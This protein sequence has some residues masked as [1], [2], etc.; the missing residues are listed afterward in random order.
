MVIAKTLNPPPGN[1]IIA[2]P[3]LLPLGGKTVNVGEV[4]S[5]TASEVWPAIASGVSATNTLS[6]GWEIPSISGAPLGQ[7]GTCFSP[8]GGC[9]TPAFLTSACCWS[10][11]VGLFACVGSDLSLRVTATPQAKPNKPKTHARISQVR[12]I[13]DSSLT[14]RTLVTIPYGPA[15]DPHADKAVLSSSRPGNKLRRNHST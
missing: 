7:I 13:N 1:T 6:A 10:D 14:E 2:A 11:V 9:Q 5:K 3:V 12:R 15:T 8:E 4:T